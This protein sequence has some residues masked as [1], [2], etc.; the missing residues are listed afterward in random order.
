MPK[1]TEKKMP[2]WMGKETKKEEMKESKATKK[3]GK[4]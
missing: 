4:K 1:K 2:P 3:G